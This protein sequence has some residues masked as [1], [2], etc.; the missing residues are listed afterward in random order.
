MYCYGE[1]FGEYPIYLRQPMVLILF[2]PGCMSQC[3]VRPGW[4]LAV[5]WCGGARR[6]A[7]QPDDE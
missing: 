6:A 2:S 4:W 5:G 7:E 3:C 1:H